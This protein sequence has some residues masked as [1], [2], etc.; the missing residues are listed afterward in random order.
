MKKIRYSFLLLILLSSA[1]S[2]CAGKTEDKESFVWQEEKSPREETFPYQDFS[3]DYGVLKDYALNEKGDAVFIYETALAAVGEEEPV[4]VDYH[5]SGQQYETFIIEYDCLENE[6][7]ERRLK[8]EKG[9]RWKKADITQEGTILLFDG[10]RCYGY[11]SGETESYMNFPAYPEGGVLITKEGGVICKTYLYSPYLLFDLKTGERT[12][13]Y[14][15]EEFLYQPVCNYNTL[16]CGDGETGLLVT[17][18]GLFEKTG[19]NWVLRVPS[20]KTSM[21]LPDF[22]PLAVFK[23]EEG[24]YTVEDYNAAYTYNQ[25]EKEEALL[26]ELKIVSLQEI[27]LIK[28]AVIRYQIAHPETTVIYEFYTKELPETREEMNILVRQLN[29]ELLSASPADIYIL[30]N[31][32]WEYYQEKGCFVD[33]QESIQPY[34]DSGN[35]YSGVLTGSRNAEG[36]FAVPLFFR[37]DFILCKESFMPYVKS[38]HSLAAYLTE[39]PEEKG[40]VPFYYSGN[41][42]GYFL[43]VLYHYYQKELF[44]DDVVTR[45]SLEEFLLSAKIIYDRMGMDSSAGTAAYKEKYKFGS[46]QIII[47]EI[48]QM[49][50]C[51][52]GNLLFYTC[53]GPG[54]A[55]IPQGF[56]SPGYE[57]A[58]MENY[59]PELLL[60][61]HTKSK[62]REEALLMLQFL[63]SYIETTGSKTGMLQL[64]IPVYKPATAALMEHQ[65]EAV[66]T[67]LGVKEDY[68]FRKDYGEAFPIYLP[69]KEDEDRLISELE[70]FSVP[71]P[72]AE[73]LTNEIYAVIK[74]NIG[75][76]FE[77]EVNLDKAVEGIYGRIELLQEEKK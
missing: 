49:V 45:D 3:S 72:Y 64:G 61:V 66:V 25:V 46:E 16:L 17:G 44:H 8:L 1:L 2:A 40:V 22:M 65:R 19:E 6:Y 15:S 57:L 69:T 12:D 13:T 71:L 43:P 26:K 11:R 73:P 42:T 39:N 10:E 67:N 14:L 24:I 70:K 7:K 34:L 31:L 5:K 47:D 60:G 23:N 36:L 37:A 68:Y 9:K 33:L 20:E 76:Y 58:A 75:G 35:Y 59:H 32:P 51:Q 18:N 29:A 50:G 52:D 21:Y 74:E 41:S 56:H 4:F 63:L 62:E 28:E 27:G 77:G 53:S 54:T 48:W 38:I 55:Y 30:D